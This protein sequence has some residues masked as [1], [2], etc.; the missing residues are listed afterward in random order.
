MTGTPGENGWYRS[1][2]TVTW[3]VAE[4]ESPA[5][6]QTS[7]C[8][9]TAITSETSGTTVTCEATSAGGSASQSVTIRRDATAPTV[10]IEAPAATTYTEGQA[11]AAGY[12]CDDGGS[13]IGAC[14][15]PVA[16]GAAIDTATA[17]ARTFTVTASDRAGNTSSRSVD[18]TVAAP[19]PPPPPAP[20][21][22]LPPPSPS[23]SSPA[24]DR[25]APTIAIVGVR[26]QGRSCTRR[27]FRARV[28]IRDGS[29]LGYARLAL[30]GRRKLNTR[31]KRFSVRIRAS[32]LRSGRHRITVAA[33]DSAGN[34]GMRSVRFTRCAMP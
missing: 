14:T 22:P 34:R 24:L 23:P 5:T 1:D 18:Y 21:P 28:R 11:V 8:D 30:D 32:R 13:G 29:A 31:N 26:G 2:V 15:G 33:R 16:S 6:L 12:D 3:T 10:T 25:A 19:P 27:D 9:P 20:P 17:G 7:G 4:A